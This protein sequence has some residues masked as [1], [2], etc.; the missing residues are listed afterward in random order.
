MGEF[1]QWRAE[2]TSE[3]VPV[4]V[5]LDRGLLAEL[6]AAVEKLSSE[7]TAHAGMM[8]D[9]DEV[10]AL[11]ERVVE[12]E[13]SVREKTRTLWISRIPGPQ[14]NDLLERH[15]ASD[16]VKAKQREQLAEAREVDPK[17]QLDVSVDWDAFAPE[18]VAACCVEPELSVEDALWLRD[19]DDK[20][21]GLPDE[22]WQ[23]LWMTCASAQTRGTTVPKHLSGIVATLASEL[24]S[25]MPPAEESPSASSGAAPRKTAKR[26]GSKATG[27]RQSRGSRSKT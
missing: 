25:T 3:R 10:K 18:A 17:A 26:T 20:W 27:K 7:R 5:V 11:A 8:H 14:W 21:P 9:P 13:R 2:A 19:G 15:K 4:E 22:Q 23:R 6:M 16:E 24:N 1:S 12:L